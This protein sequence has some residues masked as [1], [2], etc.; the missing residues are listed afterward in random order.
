MGKNKRGFIFIIFL[1]IILAVVLAV[2]IIKDKKILKNNITEY[3]EW[4][5][6]QSAVLSDVESEEDETITVN[7]VE[8]DETKTFYEKLKSNEPVNILVLGDDIALSEGR[9]SNDGIWTEGLKYIIKDIYN[10]EC[11]LTNASEVG[12][13]I[14]SAV[15]NVINSNIT[16]YDLVILC[17]GY[18]NY[19]SGSDIE[20]FRSSYTNIIDELHKQNN[21]ITILPMVQSELD[22]NN[23]YGNI[24]KEVSL[25]KG[26]SVIDTHEAFKNSGIEYALSDN[27]V[28]PN[29]TGY[30]IY[31]ERI[32]SV[33]NNELN[34]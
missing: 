34:K 8:E 11:S 33:I 24:V 14:E 19:I 32:E 3:S 16:S 29:D 5:E 7:R 18:S 31:T 28:L 30:Q 6:E 23:P 13:L 12:Y 9:R 22:T 20:S 21:N 15:Q 25:S 26:L 2:G 27:G 1:C 10:T 17:F 4:K